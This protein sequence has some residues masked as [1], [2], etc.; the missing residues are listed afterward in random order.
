M[1]RRNTLKALAATSIGVA[2][3]GYWAK[4]LDYIP[5]LMSQSFFKP[6]EQDLITSIADT[7]IPKGKIY[8]ALELGVPVYLL[9]YFEKCE[10]PEVQEN[11][12]LQLNNLNQTAKQKFNQKFINCP[13]EQRE[14][15][16]LAFANSDA[17]PRQEFFNLM[18]SQTIWGFRSTKEVMTRHYDYQVA[19]GHYYGCVD[20][21]YQHPS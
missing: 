16:L 8:G 13:Q 20:I 18:K 21:T 5:D 6:S 14:E 11:I 12:K 3:L 10:K 4:D 15:L 19:P 7:I 17:E 9:S 1:T 2:A